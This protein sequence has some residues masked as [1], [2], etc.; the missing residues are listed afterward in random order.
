MTWVIIIA[1]MIISS[2]AASWRQGR[3]E[4]RLR[5]EE[6]KRKER[7]IKERRIEVDEYDPYQNKRSKFR[8]KMP[9]PPFEK[10]W[11]WDVKIS[12]ADPS[13]SNILRF[14][15]MGNEAHVVDVTADIVVNG[16]SILLSTRDAC[17]AVAPKASANVDILDCFNKSRLSESK[18]EQFKAENV[19]VL[20]F[21]PL[22][23]HPS[24]QPILKQPTE[25]PTFAKQ[26][27]DGHSKVNDKQTKGI[28]EC[29]ITHLWSGLASLAISL[30]YLF[31]PA[32]N[33]TFTYKLIAVPFL[34]A[35]LVIAIA[36]PAILIRI[37][38][39]KRVGVFV[40]KSLVIFWV[41]L[42]ALFCSAVLAV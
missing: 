29:R 40:Y 41:I 28:L 32:T 24:R 17:I 4:S 9:S 30:L 39:G 42:I 5:Y 20:D 2:I 7:V 15:N 25:W 22:F 27:C 21:K 13:N 33:E 11:F 34:V 23:L 8:Y 18:K 38:L 31:D 37:I 36:F 35:I 3:E 10:R 16:F 14:Q 6:G 12:I 1:L 19:R 26:I